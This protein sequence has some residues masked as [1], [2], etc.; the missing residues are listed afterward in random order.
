ML[1]HNYLEA[2]KRIVPTYMLNILTLRCSILVSIRAREMMQPFY[3]HGR[4]RAR[5]IWRLKIPSN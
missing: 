1:Q 3:M 2:Y 4:M 5:R